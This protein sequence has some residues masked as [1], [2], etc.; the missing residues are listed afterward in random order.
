MPQ[1]QV[2]VV[3]RKLSSSIGWVVSIVKKVPV[4]ID[5]VE[6]YAEG[7]LNNERDSLSEKFAE[8][9]QAEWMFTITSLQ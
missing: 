2:V 5:S 1:Q 8:F 6:S 3:L 9:Y 7:I 4:D